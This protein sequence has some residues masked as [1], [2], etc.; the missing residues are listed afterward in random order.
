[1]YVGWRDGQCQ[2]DDAPTGERPSLWPENQECQQNLKY[3]AG[4][5]S[6]QWPGPPGWNDSDKKIG[7]GEMRDTAAK[8][9]GEDDSKT[10]VAKI[11]DHVFIQLSGAPGLAWRHP[12]YSGVAAKYQA[13]L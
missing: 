10:S 12:V 3:A 8:E 4:I 9:P 13:I 2:R 5:D 6:E 11:F 7:I 1:M